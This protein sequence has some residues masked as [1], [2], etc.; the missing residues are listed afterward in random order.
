MMR[1]W[2]WLPGA[3]I[4]CTTEPTPLPTKEAVAVFDR[5]A[6]PPMYQMLYTAPVLPAQTTNQ[7]QLRML[8][9]IR[10][11]GLSNSQLDQLEALRVMSAE[12]G[13]RIQQA[14]SE[15]VARYSGEEEAIYGAMLEQVSA[16][17]PIDEP[18][19]S[20]LLGQLEELQAGGERET[21]LLKIR[22]EG[23]R[24]ILEAESGFLRS[25]SPS[26]EMMLA[27]ALFVL[28]GRID[29]VANPGD[30]RSLIGTTYEPGQYAV[31]TRGTGEGASDPLNIGALW[32]DDGELTGYALHEARREV[33]LYLILLEPGLQEAIVKAKALLGEPSPP[34]PQGS[35]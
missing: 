11:M 18:V 32:T 6:A 5:Q 30:Y 3:L 17:V 35:P 1:L 27:D 19:F 16:G 29:P 10:H 23:M 9:W 25:L 21:E 24:S 12:R 8:I 14:E 22:M 4:S 7:Q 33:L 13:A 26:Q 2:I 31:L 28:R 34:P 20:D 15:V